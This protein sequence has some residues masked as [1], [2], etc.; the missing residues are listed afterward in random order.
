MNNLCKL[1]VQ[2]RQQENKLTKR[3]LITSFPEH[4]A[5]SEVPDILKL[6]RREKLSNFATCRFSL[7][8]CL[9][10]PGGALAPQSLSHTLSN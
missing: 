8:S 9:P 6:L 1:I 10:N 3:N 7:I 5:F 4:S 2:T